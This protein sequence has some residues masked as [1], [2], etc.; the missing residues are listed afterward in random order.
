MSLWD[1]VL[2]RRKEDKSLDEHLREYKEQQREL[3]VQMQ[4]IAYMQQQAEEKHLR[5]TLIRQERAI[6][7]TVPINNYGAY[8]PMGGYVGASMSAMGNATY[9]QP[10]PTWMPIPADEV[11]EGLVPVEPGPPLPDCV[12][13]RYPV[14]P[15]EDYCHD[16]LGKQAVP[17]KTMMEVV[18]DAVLELRYKNNAMPETL[19]LNRTQYEQ[20]RREASGNQA[21]QHVSTDPLFYGAPIV[22]GCKILVKD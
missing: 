4:K 22:Y 17:E 5:E 2:G 9:A 20:L 1:R 14:L 6:S 13:K 7:G 18:R 8:A 3:T 21:F 10:W 11:S 16:C 12:C 15:S 19:V